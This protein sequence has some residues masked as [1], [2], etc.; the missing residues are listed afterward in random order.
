[1]NETKKLLAVYQTEQKLRG[2]QA[3]L[4][5]AERFLSEQERRLTT[6]G[7]QHGSFESQLRQIDAS[8]KESEDEMARM[9]E[10]MEKLREEMNNA[11]TNKEYQAFLVEVN[12]LKIER[13]RVEEEVLGLLEQADAVKTEIEQSVTSK[14]ER[15]KVRD[16]AKQD[17]D[18]RHGEIKNRVK[19]LEIE[20]DQLAGEV[21]PRILFELQ[22][23]LDDRDEDAMAGIE[24]IDKK[25]HEI[26]CASCMM[27]LPI[28]LLSKLLSGALTSCSN[29]GCFLYLDEDTAAELQP[30]A[31]R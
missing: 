1:M 26:S 31:K 16:V 8:T 20:R 19:E 11:R 27:S 18:T 12:G 24:I 7:E 22:R 14:D 9:D 2:L 3:R 15:Q 21:N 10:R 30:T 5:A 25:R 29:C 23:L 28:E 17:R 13:G 6:L 4:G